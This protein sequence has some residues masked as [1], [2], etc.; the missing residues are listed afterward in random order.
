MRLFPA[1]AQGRSTHHGR[2][3]PR[4]KGCG[5]ITVGGN[6]AGREIAAAAGAGPGGKD[7]SRAARSVAQCAAL[8]AGRGVAGGGSAG[9]CGVGAAAATRAGSAGRHAAAGRRASGYM[10]TGL[11]FRL[12]VLPNWLDATAG[13]AIAVGS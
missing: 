3:D 13:A 2:A 10:L 7:R 12:P 9:L 5:I 8:G 6:R 4:G 11:P 1:G